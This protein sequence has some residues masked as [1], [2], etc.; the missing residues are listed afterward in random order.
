MKRRS[1]PSLHHRQR[2]G[3][4]T[5]DDEDPLGRMSDL[6]SDSHTNH[7]S[8]REF[9]PLL[10]RRRSSSA[11]LTASPSSSSQ[12][13]S[14]DSDDNRSVSSISAGGGMGGGSNSISRLLSPTSS[15]SSSSRPLY[16]PLQD[17]MPPPQPSSRRLTR[18]L[19]SEL[20]S[21]T[22]SPGTPSS[23]LHQH[24]NHHHH[25]HH[26]QQQQQEQPSSSSSSQQ[27]PQPDFGMDEIMVDP[28]AS[29]ASPSSSSSLTDGRKFIAPS[30]PPLSSVR[31]DIVRR[32]SSTERISHH[33]HHRHH[34]RSASSSSAEASGSGSGSGS[35]LKRSDPERRSVTRRSSLL[36]R[37]KALARVMSQADEETRPA[38]VEMRRERDMTNQIKARLGRMSMDTDLSANASG[39][40]SSS[41]SNDAKPIASGSVPA[42]AWARIRDPEG[43]PTM[44]PYHASKLNP[45]MEMTNFQCDNLPS[46]IHQTYK[47]IKR[48]ASEDRFEP[49]PT[50]SL[51]RRAVSPSVSASG[52]PV[53]SAISSPPYSFYGSSPTSNAAARAQQKPGQL[54]SSSFNLQD[55]SGGLSRMS[56]SE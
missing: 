6:E 39:S 49:Y 53:L 56:L 37:S 25:H 12:K 23:R 28:T 1:T 13:M 43:S 10:R 42:V 19:S 18:S 40:G 36:P 29:N 3:S 15:F 9:P 22:W 50:S 11:S 5:T 27:P 24:Q 35:P 41:S 2:R 21:S 7:S 30:I 55:A 34:H 14:I 33:H 20:A 32:S 54:S 46:P 44:A 51:K 38:D 8:I 48:K 17:T 52:S 45:E 4:Y 31:P 26:Q 47:S 16:Y